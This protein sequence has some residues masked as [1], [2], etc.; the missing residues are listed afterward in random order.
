MLLV[1]SGSE[2]GVDEVTIAF[3]SFLGLLR[4]GGRNIEGF[5]VG[6]VLMMNVHKSLLLGDSLQLL[7]L[8]TV[9]PNLC[10]SDCVKVRTGEHFT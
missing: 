7:T 6:M 1:G 10:H 4:S 8:L 9:S 3:S 2:V 5:V